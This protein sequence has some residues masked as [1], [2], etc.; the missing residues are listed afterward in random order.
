MKTLNGYEV[1]DAK[2]REEL[3]ILKNAG[4]ATEEYVDNA[5]A[6]IPE[7]DLSKHAL[8]SE[9][10]DKVSQLEN[11][12]KYITL[13]EVPKTDLTAYALKSELPKVPT[14]V[15]AF[16]NDAGYLTQHQSLSAYAKKDDIPDITTK[17]D[18]YH[19]HDNLYDPK[20]AAQQ[21]KDDLLGGASAAY[22]TL[23]ELGTL[24]IDNQ[25]AIEALETIAS[26]KADRDHTHSQYLTEHQDISNL[27]PK[28]YVNTKVDE[29]ADDL[30]AYVDEAETR[31][32]MRIPKNVSQ[33]TNDA[34]Y[35]KSIPAEYVT[36]SELQ[37]KNYL[38][39]HQSLTA[40][41]TKVYVQNTVADSQPDLSKYAKKTDIPDVDE[42]IKEIPAEYVT[43][44]E[45]AAKKYAT[46]SYVAEAIANI[47]FPEGTDLSVYAK[48]EDIPTN[49]SAFTNDA[50]YL[51]QHIDISGKADKNH[52]HSEYLTS[53]QDL[54]AYAKKSEIPDISGKADKNHTHSEYLTAHQDI[55][56]K[57]D[58]NHNHDDKYDAKGAA[59]AVKNELL[60][61]AGAAYDT[62][63]ELGDLIDENVDAIEA[64]EQ[65]AAGKADK[66]HTHTEYA[67]SSHSHTQ[68]ANKT[69]KHAMAD[70][71]DYVAPS[72]AGY[73]TE[74]Y[75]NDALANI[76]IP[77]GD[78]PTF[79]LDFSDGVNYPSKTCGSEMVRFAE[80]F[81]NNDGAG[82][83]ISDTKEP[84]YYYPAIITRADNNSKQMFTFQKA[85]INMNT[86]YSE[87]KL[88]WDICRILW[89]ET[90]NEW[91]YYIVGSSSTTIATK[92]YVDNAI[93]N[94]D[95]EVPTPEVSVGAGHCEIVLPASTGSTYKD[96]CAITDPAT[97]EC[98]DKILA[99]ELPSCSIGGYTV[100]G[101]RNTGTENRYYLFTISPPNSNNTFFTYTYTFYKVA[102]G[103][104]YYNKH[105]T[106]KYFISKTSELTNDSDFTTKAYVDEAIA[107]IDVST[108][109][110]CEASQTNAAAIAA[111][112]VRVEDTEQGIT[113]LE[114]DMETLESR[115]TALDGS[116]RRVNV[117][118]A[119]VAAI[120]AQYLNES[121]VKALI[122]EALEVIENGSY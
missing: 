73:A 86:V 82:V 60:N 102:E 18:K 40:Y 25:D 48:K 65:V 107:N 58:K 78:H 64:L 67:A 88:H 55:S 15:S 93:A 16:D 27:A 103:W 111:L 36:E 22:D 7:V 41:A 32:E 91:Q 26:G 51:T 119:A 53:H 59:Q 112:T 44:S 100:V 120:E 70:I 49:V 113:A 14:K 8:K 11:D 69:H 46:E 122:N 38:T 105:S 118:E 45:L 68:Y 110:N 33:L 61:G 114:N 10:P 98:L 115:V 54:S 2:A 19:T 35:I 117:L 57:A 96:T 87:A 108:S 66:D 13:N 42:F 94:I 12:R 81:S 43:D 4:H 21:V 6:A 104:I 47:E 34:G 92:N 50:G 74:Q 97:I 39:E 20:G 116:G 72:L 71:T 5:I 84:G 95:I 29:L 77:D 90:A 56:G 85:S 89:S 79:Y 30:A 80:Y 75:V 121:E 28:T 52:T 37:A 63:K 9:I 31:I 23:R 62:L 1:V 106:Y 76:D 99:G 101:A 24:I 3:E 17:A 109:G 83:F